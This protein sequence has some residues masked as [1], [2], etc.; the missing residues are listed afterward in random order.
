MARASHTK[1]LSPAAAPGAAPAASAA[2]R[3]AATAAPTV[4]VLAA[5]RT[6]ESKG[7]LDAGGGGWGGESGA[8]GQRAPRGRAARPSA[9]ASTEGESALA[10][11]GSVHRRGDRR[12]RKRQQPTTDWE[13]GAVVSGSV[14]RRGERRGRKRQQPTTD[15]ESGA[16]ASDS[17]HRRGESVVVSDC[18]HRRWELGMGNWFSV[19]T[20]T[21]CNWFKW[22]FLPNWHQPHL[23]VKN[24]ANQFR[25]ASRYRACRSRN[26]ALHAPVELAHATSV[27][28]SQAGDVM[29]SSMERACSLTT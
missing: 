23:H 11:S 25:S 18:D 2:R 12:G 29:L 3:S 6:G 13:S 9:A 20:V 24:C 4:A 15:W 26:L 28:S 1:L 27:H 16:V 19:F 22:L 14:H 7:R 8:V 5:A 21:G 10:V 17:D